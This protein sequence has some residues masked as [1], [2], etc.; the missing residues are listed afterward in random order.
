[1]AIILGCLLN[2]VAD[3]L[4]SVQLITCLRPS[5]KRTNPTH[6]PCINP[7]LQPNN[8]GSVVQVK[9]LGI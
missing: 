7:A 6:M 9:V 1:M 3:N 8:S 2:L 5:Q 4:Q